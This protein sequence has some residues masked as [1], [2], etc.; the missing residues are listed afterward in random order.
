MIKLILKPYCIDGYNMLK[1]VRD[2]VLVGLLICHIEP[3]EMGS[4]L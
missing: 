1:R 4:T 3:V 2:D